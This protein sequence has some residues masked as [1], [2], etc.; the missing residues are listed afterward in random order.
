MGVT[1]QWN[2]TLSRPVKVLISTRKTEMA[3]SA[4]MRGGR[5]ANQ[6]ETARTHPVGGCLTGGDEGPVT[7]TVR[8][9]GGAGF[10]AVLGPGFSSG[11]AVHGHP[12]ARDGRRDILHLLAAEIIEAEGELV[13]DLIVDRARD[14]DAAG[15][16]QLLQ[17]RR[18]VDAVAIDVGV[19]RPS[20]RRD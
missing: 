11:G 9:R 8:S 6:S 10:S 5:D 4:A 1:A 14:Q 17:P 12:I 2:Q 13:V 7:G 15:I 16:G 18:D 20:R 19:R 3:M